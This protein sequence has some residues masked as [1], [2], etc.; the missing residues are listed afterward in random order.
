[1]ATTV[2]AAVARAPRN[3]G[4]GSW[5][6]AIPAAVAAKNISNRKSAMVAARDHQRSIHLILLGSASSRVFRW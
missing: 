1:M 3:S 5:S 6:T 2:T 4:A